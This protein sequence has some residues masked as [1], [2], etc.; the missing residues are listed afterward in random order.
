VP[1]PRR[2]MWADRAGLTRGAVQHHFGNVDDLC[3]AVVE[4]FGRKL[5]EWSSLTTEVFVR[6]SPAQGLRRQTFPRPYSN[7]RPAA[8]MT[9]PHFCS[10]LRTNCAVA[11]TPMRPTVM[12]RFSS[13]A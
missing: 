7:F 8:V 2:T 5:D 10:S 13:A 4:D 3:L 1:K 12:P 11:S 6:L 9:P